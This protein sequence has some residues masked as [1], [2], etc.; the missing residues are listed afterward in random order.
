MNPKKYRAGEYITTVADI[1]YQ[2]SSGNYIMMR[3]GDRGWVPK[4]PSVIVSMT[5][6]TIRGMVSHKRLAVA[7]EN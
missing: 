4:H 1:N 3:C 6:H 7:I 5:L 2:V